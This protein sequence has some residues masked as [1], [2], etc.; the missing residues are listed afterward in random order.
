MV[1]NFDKHGNDSLWIRHISKEKLNYN[2]TLSHGWNTGI[3]HFVGK[4]YNVF[5]I[6]IKQLWIQLNFTRTKYR[7]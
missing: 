5:R 3:Y 2:K 4:G 6:M 7:H 1:I